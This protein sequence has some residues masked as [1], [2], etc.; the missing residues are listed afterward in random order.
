MTEKEGDLE[1]RK[2]GERALGR[3]ANP[4]VRG[5]DLGREDGGSFITKGVRLI[6]TPAS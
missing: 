6:R 1:L 3:E 5:P 4:P 2:K